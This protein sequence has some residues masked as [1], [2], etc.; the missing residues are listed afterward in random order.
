MRDLSYVA[1]FEIIIAVVINNPVL[2]D[3]TLCGSV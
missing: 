1:I 3:T 2:C